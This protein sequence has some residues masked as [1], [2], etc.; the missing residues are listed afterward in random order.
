MRYMT[1]DELTMYQILRDDPACRRSNWEAVR[2]FYLKQYG[3]S[4]PA[5]RGL[6]TIWTVERMIRTLKSEYPNKLTDEKEREIKEEE[7]TKYKDMAR[8][9]NKPVKP[10]NEPKKEEQGRLGVFGEPSWWN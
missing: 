6:P 3:I 9:E 1:D 8:D 4:L 2:S 10:Q 5:L 7:V